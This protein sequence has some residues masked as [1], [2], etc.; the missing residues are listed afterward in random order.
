[1]AKATITHII[2]DF[3]G[4]LVDTVD[5]GTDILDEYIF[6]RFNVHITPNIRGEF[7][8]SLAILLSVLNI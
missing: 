3:D 1:M 6:D 8:L 2:F 4:T 5:K 7:P